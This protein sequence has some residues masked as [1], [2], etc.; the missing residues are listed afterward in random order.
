[1]GLPNRYL[2]LI[3]ACVI[4]EATVEVEVTRAEVA[5]RFDRRT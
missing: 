4:N 5:I 1:M 2:S 3:S